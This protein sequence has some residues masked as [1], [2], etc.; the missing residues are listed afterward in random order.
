[1]KTLAIDGMQKFDATI[2]GLIKSQMT[3][4]VVVGY[5]QNYA[6]YVHE[7]L[8]AKHKKGRTAKY[9]EKAVAMVAP[10]AGDIVA[11]ATKAGRT[12]AQGMLLIGLRIQRESMKLVP[13][14]TGALRASAFTA[15]ESQQLAAMAVAQ[16][17]SEAIKIMGESKKRVKASKKALKKATKRAANR[18][19]AA[20]KKGNKRGKKK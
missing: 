3:D 8:N 5:T 18:A 14:D 7:D 13:I 2:Q 1:M 16:A 9:L 4:G 10:L 15:R 19:K 20:K 11:E 12:V 6:V 17:K